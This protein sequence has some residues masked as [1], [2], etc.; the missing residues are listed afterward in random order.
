MLLVSSFDDAGR[1]RVQR[2][3][4]SA[5][6]NMEGGKTIWSLNERMLYRGINFLFLF[7]WSNQTTTTPTTVRSAKQTAQ[8]QAFVAFVV[9]SWERDWHFEL[10]REDSTVGGRWW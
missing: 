9:D 10:C 5:G 8:Y 6:A 7:F 2:K 1:V 4:R 3:I